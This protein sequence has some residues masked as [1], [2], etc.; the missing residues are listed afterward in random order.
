MLAEI[1]ERNEDKIQFCLDAK[2]FLVKIFDVSFRTLN[3]MEEN[4]AKYA[5]LNNAN[6]AQ[7]TAP[8]DP[9]KGLQ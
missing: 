9:K 5:N 2:F 6:A 8:P 4:A 1:S 7:G 3:Q